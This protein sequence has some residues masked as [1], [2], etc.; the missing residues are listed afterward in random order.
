MFLLFGFVYFSILLMHASNDWNS[1]EKFLKVIFRSYL[2]LI[3][4]QSEEKLLCLMS[5][6]FHEINGNTSFMVHVD[7][8]KVFL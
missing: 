4:F 5:K 8:H 3:P 1:F 6:V 7:L 2:A